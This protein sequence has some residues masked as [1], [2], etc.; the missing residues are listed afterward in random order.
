MV[1]NDDTFVTRKRV[2]PEIRIK[3]NLEHAKWD[4]SNRKCLMVIKSF[5][6][7]AIRGAIP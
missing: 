2:H 1:K 3:Y 5:I 7:E 4:S 6:V